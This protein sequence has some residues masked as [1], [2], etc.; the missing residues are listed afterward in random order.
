MIMLSSCLAGINCKYNGKNNRHP[1]F[2]SMAESE[3]VV[4]VC[5]EE[6]AGLPIPRSP[7]EICNGTGE[8]VLAGQAKVINREE[9]DIT[10]QFIEGAKIALEICQ[11]NG[12][13]L[14]ILRR[15]SPSCG[16]DHIYDGT[17]TSTLQDGDGVFAVLLKRNGIRVISDEEYLKKGV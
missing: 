17:F 1:A 13:D 3:E 6:L 12:V 16:C 14:A 10:K 4:L 5:P 9:R 15:N 7:S 2:V 11:N 8:D